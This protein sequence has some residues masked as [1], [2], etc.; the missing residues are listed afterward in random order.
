MFLYY[1]LHTIQKKGRFMT[2]KKEGI[3]C[4][5]RIPVKDVCL[6]G[7]VPTW[8]RNIIILSE[9]KAELEEWADEYEH[10]FLRKNGTLVF[11]FIKDC[12]KERG[13][14]FTGN[15]NLIFAGDVSGNKDNDSSI[16]MNEVFWLAFWKA[17]GDTSKK[18]LC[19]EAKTFQKQ[20]KQTKPMFKYVLP[21]LRDRSK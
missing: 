3:K 17:A 18:F 13:C 12:E 21:I 10:I 20:F 4:L 14:I 8:I 7:D 11:E 16:V 9:I 15:G 19:K 6:P 2:T 5:E 1:I